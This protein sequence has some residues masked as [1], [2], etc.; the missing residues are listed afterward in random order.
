M[1][2]GLK[3]G[4]KALILGAGPIG[5]LVAFWARRMGAR[6]VVVAD[7]HEFQRTCAA[8]VGA[9]GFAVSGPGLASAFADMA[10][11]PPDIVFEC[12]GKRG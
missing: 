1:R 11:G 10:G 8:A 5:L 3:P 4:D 9:T 12:V 6:H 2:S 7:I